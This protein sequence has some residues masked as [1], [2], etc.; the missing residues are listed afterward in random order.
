MKKQP[1]KIFTVII[2]GKEYDVYDIEGKEHGG[3]N[4]T[5]KTWWLYFSNRIPDI[6]PVD[7]DSWEPYCVGT[8]RRLWEIK[9]K[10][11][12]TTKEKWG[13]TQ[14]NNHTSVEMWCNNKLVYA[15]GTGGKYI[16]FAMAKVQYLQV[17]LSEHSY[18]FF[19]PEKENGR[20][21][22]L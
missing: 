19:E 6:P 20:K 17:M 4:D 2:R 12:N 21:I 15:F 3:Y 18:N 11:H 14:F 7:S 22:K 13:S 16:D 9:I 5:P 1:R 8:L 10:Q